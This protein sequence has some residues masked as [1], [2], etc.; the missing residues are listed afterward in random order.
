MGAGPTRLRIL[1]VGSGGREH[2]LAWA[3]HKEAEVICAPGNPGIAEDVE[4]APVAV[5]DQAR[6]V[7]LAR[8]RAID[9]VVIGP[10]DPLLVGL[11]DRFREA[12]FRAFGPG[13]DA[14]QLEGSKVFSKALMAEAGIP[15]AR[16]GAFEAPEP[17]K[18]FASALWAEG[19]GVVVKAS[20][21][22][23]GKGAIVCDSL[24]SANETIDDML[25]RCTLG[26]AGKSIVVEQRL[27]GPEFSLLT[28]VS[29]EQYWSLPVAQDY[30]AAYDGNEGPNTGGMG[31]YSPV[32]SVPRPL[33]EQAER[34]VVE[35]L[36]RALATR[37]IDYRGVLF[38]GLLVHD[39]RPFCL[40]YNVRFGDP[41]TQSIVCRLGRGLAAALLACADGREIPPVDV[42]DNAAVTVVVASRG[43][44]EAP[45]KGFEVSLP[46]QP[47]AKIFH[48]GTAHKDGRLI[49]SGG[50]VFGVTGVGSNL[51]EARLKAYETAKAIQFEGAWFRSDIAAS[52]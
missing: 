2:A 22:A 44:P 50:R 12:G 21:A 18:Q 37:G 47:S 39:G 32:P 3:L 24:E 17:A 45:E 42:L 28:L 19:S 29:G 49:N 52:P 1:V 20:G 33:V 51:A 23:L 15:T 9:L 7:K 36:L 4:T 30:K 11:A 13:A 5:T 35:P 48:A 25:V 31:S 26:D 41:E 10:E 46:S 38:S 14:A 40:E 27:H 6:L 34:E 8:D 16:H 43:Y